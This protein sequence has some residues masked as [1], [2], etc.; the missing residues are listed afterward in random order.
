MLAKQDIA[1]RLY[2]TTTVGSGRFFLCDDPDV[3]TL[4]SLEGLSTRHNKV[5]C[6][7]LLPAAENCEDILTS[8]SGI[9]PRWESTRH[10]PYGIATTSD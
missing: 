4:G 5:V 10:A 7:A 3:P 1:G 6:V 8:C 2:P 9:A